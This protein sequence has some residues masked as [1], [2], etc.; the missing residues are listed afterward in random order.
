MPHDGH[1]VLF[2]S[3]QPQRLVSTLLVDTHIL[4]LQIFI[5][6]AAGGHRA[7]IFS[8]FTNTSKTRAFEKLQVRKG[9]LEHLSHS[10][11]LA[12]F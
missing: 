4:L 12:Q 7:H 10:Q 9:I 3:Q 2:V 11:P 6:G 5:V 1:C 8:E